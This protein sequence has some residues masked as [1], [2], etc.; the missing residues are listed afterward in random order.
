M[1]A[2]FVALIDHHN[3][4]GS[5]NVLHKCEFHWLRR[6]GE[7]RWSSGCLVGE[8]DRLGQGE[9]AVGFEAGHFRGDSLP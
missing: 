1:N 8:I 7:D 2:A 4:S 3:F 6:M 9:L 5:C